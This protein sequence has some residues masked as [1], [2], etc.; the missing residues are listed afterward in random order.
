MDSENLTKEELADF[1]EFLQERR[2]SNAQLARFFN[3]KPATAN[4]WFRVGRMNRLKAREFIRQEK[5]R[6]LKAFE[7]VEKI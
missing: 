7:K 1:K 5:E 4:Y 6:A 2:I 3:K